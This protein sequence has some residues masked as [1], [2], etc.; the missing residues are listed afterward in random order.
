MPIL[1]QV[2][3][4]KGNLNILK[5]LPAPVLRHRVAQAANRTPSEQAA[6]ACLRFL[7]LQP[8]PAP[9]RRWRADVPP[10]ASPASWQDRGRCSGGCTKNRDSAAWQRGSRYCGQ[11]DHPGKTGEAGSPSGA[12][13]D[14]EGVASCYAR[15]GRFVASRTPGE[16]ARNQAPVRPPGIFPLAGK[17]H[18]GN[19]GGHCRRLVMAL[20]SSCRIYC[21]TKREENRKSVVPAWHFWRLPFR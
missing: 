6:V 1:V 9:P 19:T 15:P 13:C 8:R 4:G 3:P 21:Q 20:K 2:Q 18:P 10:V 14:E 17:R 12:C 5:A 11:A 16:L 7:P